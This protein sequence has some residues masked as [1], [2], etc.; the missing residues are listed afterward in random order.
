LHLGGANFLFGDGSVRFLRSVPGDNADG[1][2]TRD[3]IAL[4]ALGTR[5]GGEV[6][7][8]FDY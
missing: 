5:A 3:S 2:Y 7:T 8:G 6:I 1:S 4:Q